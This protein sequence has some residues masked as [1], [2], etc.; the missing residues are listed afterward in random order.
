MT[1]CKLH[2]KRRNNRVLHLKRWLNE[3]QSRHD[4]RCASE[5]MHEY[6]I[7]TIQ[8]CLINTD[9][10]RTIFSDYVYGLSRGQHLMKLPTIM[11]GIPHLSRLI[12]NEKQQLTKPSSLGV[13]SPPSFFR[14][15]EVLIS[16]L[17]RNT[18]EVS[19]AF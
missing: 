19:T 7:I 8:K 12:V 13:S 14:S 11:L 15:D 5:T 2:V 9:N 1:S 6:R 10:K 16:G 4:S 3:M 17:Y 18:Q